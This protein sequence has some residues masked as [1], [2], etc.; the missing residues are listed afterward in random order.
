M[1][2]TIKKPSGHQG[3]YAHLALKQAL[4]SGW[5]LINNRIFDFGAES[6]K[7]IEY[8]DIKDNEVFTFF[9]LEDKNSI[10]VRTLVKA[11]Y[12]GAYYHP[13]QICESMYNNDVYAESNGFK[14]TVVK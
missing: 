14:T 11:T 1:V 4:P 9:S 5:E 3:G 8:Q 10:T 12:I 2:T 6:N 13:K 7:G